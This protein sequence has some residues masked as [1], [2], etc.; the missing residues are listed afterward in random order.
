MSLWEH[1]PVWLMRTRTRGRRLP[2]PCCYFP[3]QGFFAAHGLAAFNARG[4]LVAQGF[5]AVQGFFAA[6]GLAAFMAQGFFAAHGLVAF[7]AQGFFAAQGLV[8]CAIVRVAELD[9]LE[10]ISELVQE[11]AVN[12]IK[13]IDALHNTAMCLLSTTARIVLLLYR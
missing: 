6:H 13:Q 3:A 1:G 4:F 7:M 8:A 12:A 2:S 9:G 11:P 5:F 10:L